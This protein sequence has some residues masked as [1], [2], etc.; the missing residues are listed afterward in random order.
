[1]AD[2]DE[3]G[4]LGDLDVAGSEADGA[5]RVGSAA[6]STEKRLWHRPHCKGF[7]GG[8]RAEAVRKRESVGKGL[9]ALGL[10]ALEGR[11]RFRN[12]KDWRGSSVFRGWGFRLEVVLFHRVGLGGSM[13]CL[14]CSLSGQS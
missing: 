4:A 11:G 12:G 13:W 3:D 10:G 5:H 2:F 6:F 8:N 1:M 7:K 14:T 9:K